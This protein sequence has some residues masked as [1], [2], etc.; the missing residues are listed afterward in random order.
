[1]NIPGVSRNGFTV[2]LRRSGGG[3]MDMLDASMADASNIGGGVEWCDAQLAIAEHAEK[4]KCA[5]PS[6][7]PTPCLRR[8]LAHIQICFPAIPR[9]PALERAACRS[10]ETIHPLECASSVFA[11]GGRARSPRSPDS[12]P[13]HGYRAVRR[14][15]A[16]AP[17]AHTLPP[18][19]AHVRALQAVRAPPGQR[20][21]AAP[22]VPCRARAPAV[23]AQH[24]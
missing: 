22:P 9:P 7:L 14:P 21:P 23:V 2:R 3:L 18:S 6:H 10:I 17:G 24:G 4:F 13:L 1:M 11:D 16:S 8:R 5:T 15:P 12:A 19:A 20:S